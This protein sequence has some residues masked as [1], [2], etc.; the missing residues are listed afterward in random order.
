LAIFF[1]TLTN[2]NSRRLKSRTPFRY[3]GQY[4]AQ[5]EILL[6]IKYPF[7]K[8]EQFIPYRFVIRQFSIFCSY[9]PYIAN[10]IIVLGWLGGKNKLIYWRHHHIKRKAHLSCIRSNFKKSA[11]FATFNN[12]C[13]D[14]GNKDKQRANGNRR[15]EKQGCR[16]GVDA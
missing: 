16:Q 9:I 11:I 3:Q 13:E 5:A 6:I 10:I 14:D 1:I 12:T 7:K 15:P 8:N 4:L 2:E